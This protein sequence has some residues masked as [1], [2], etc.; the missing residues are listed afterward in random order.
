MNQAEF[1]EESIISDKVLLGTKT[2]GIKG[3]VDVY[4]K[5]RV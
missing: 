2:I 3:K 4:R 1:D 5:K